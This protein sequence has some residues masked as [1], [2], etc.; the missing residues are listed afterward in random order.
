MRLSSRD[1]AVNIGKNTVYGVV[2]SLSQVL[3]RIVTVPT[4]VAFL[5]VEGYGIWSIIMATGA[6]M[7]FGSAG[8]KSAFQKYVAEG[9]GKDDHE[10]TSKLLSTGTFGILAISLVALVPVA[11]YSKTLAAAA[12]VPARFMDSASSSITLLALLMMLSNFA[13]VY[14]A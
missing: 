2:A 7:R 11:F 14:E 12:G 4:I 6:Y 5:G 1:L 9:I 8:M 3:T 10:L 13:A